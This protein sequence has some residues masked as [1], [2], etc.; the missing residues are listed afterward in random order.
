MYLF[1]MFSLFEN[2]MHF[3]CVHPFPSA[4]QLLSGLPHTS[5][6][7]LQLNVL[8][9]KNV[10]TRR[11]QLVK[12]TDYHSPKHQELQPSGKRRL[13]EELLTVP[14]ASPSGRGSSG[15]ILYRLCADNCRCC[16]FLR[17]ASCPILKILSL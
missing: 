2:F 9:E 11:F 12:P 6:S 8:F 5:H 13:P 10:R 7:P 17:T 16:L 15:L 1:L 3:D 4:P 14:S